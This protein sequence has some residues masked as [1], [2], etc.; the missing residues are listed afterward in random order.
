MSRASEDTHHY[1]ARRS[2]TVAGIVGGRRHSLYLRGGSSA[3]IIVGTSAACWHYSSPRR[4][5]VTISHHTAIF[6]DPHNTK[7]FRPIFFPTAGSSIDL[8]HAYQMGF[9]VGG[10]ELAAPCAAKMNF[11]HILGH[12]IQAVLNE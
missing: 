10:N 7:T 12:L 1:L 4:R 5:G 6:V 2:S 11:T 8:L 3:S 9:H